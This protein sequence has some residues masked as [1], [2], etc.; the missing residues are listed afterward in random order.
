MPAGLP[1]LSIESRARFLLSLASVLQALAFNGFDECLDEECGDLLRSKMLSGL[2]SPRVL[3]PPVPRVVEP[4][5]TSRVE[6]RALGHHTTHIERRQRADGGAR[7][8]RDRRV[9]TVLEGANS[10]R[11]ARE[12]GIGVVFE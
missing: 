2:L 7:V 10:P 1:K 3:L 8:R 9:E 11:R 12:A 4:A 5:A 6:A